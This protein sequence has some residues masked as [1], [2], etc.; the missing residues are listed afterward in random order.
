[1]ARLS[2]ETLEQGRNYIRRSDLEGFI[3]W[4]EGTGV[5][6]N[7]KIVQRQIETLIR[8]GSNDRA[9][10]LF[11]ATYPRLDP[12]VDLIKSVLILFVMGIIVLGLTGGIKYLFLG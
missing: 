2:E 3:K 4:S 9:V 7:H 11:E 6:Q 12:V 1:M 10:A 8:I 5:I